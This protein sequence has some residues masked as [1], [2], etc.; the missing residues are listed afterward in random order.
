MFSLKR[1]VNSNIEL[2]ATTNCGNGVFAKRDIS[3]GSVACTWMGQLVNAPAPDDDYCIDHLN[4]HVTADRNM[5]G[6]QLANHSCDPNCIMQWPELIAARDIKEGEELT[7][8]YGW[9]RV[10]PPPCRCGSPYCVGTMGLPECSDS[11]SE[12]INLDLERI[13][14]M[15]SSA[16]TRG[17][18]ALVVGV[19]SGV[20][21]CNL[22]AVSL[23][24]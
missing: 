2:R 6:A 20:A 16:R 19:M 24:A 3:H 9:S 15:L 21:R 18:D 10:N 8:Y 22:D 23:L 7:W 11:T 1:N 17:N 13:R 4:G 12:Q 14:D 5:P